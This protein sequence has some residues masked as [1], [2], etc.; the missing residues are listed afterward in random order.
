MQETET[1]A[2]EVQV[3]KQRSLAGDGLQE[4]PRS[5]AG[6]RVPSRRL[7]FR[8]AVSWEAAAAGPHFRAPWWGA[9]RTPRPEGRSA[10][11]GWWS[12]EP[13]W[14]PRDG[15]V[16]EGWGQTRFHW[17]GTAEGCVRLARCG[18]C[19]RGSW[20]VPLKSCQRAAW[21]ERTRAETDPGDR[22]AQGRGD[23]AGG[24]KAPRRVTGRGRRAAGR[25]GHWPCGPVSLFRGRPR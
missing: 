7:T 23:S 1:R 20:R 11:G 22:R 18:P 10:A 15:A 17:R 6:Q 21:A 2:E 24:G 4:L 9:G 14:D 19:G 12:S 8:E 13:A 5:R 3:T 16:A 25:A